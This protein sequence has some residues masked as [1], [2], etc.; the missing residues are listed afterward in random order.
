MEGGLESCCLRV[1]ELVRLRFNSRMVLQD[2]SDHRFLSLLESRSYFNLIFI[3]EHVSS[4]FDRFLIG[5][6]FQYPQLHSALAFPQF[7]Q[8]D[9]YVVLGTLRS[10]AGSSS[11]V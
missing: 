3:D 5:T 2:I 4:R 11:G 8:L 7:L 1:E 10:T 6:A 9:D